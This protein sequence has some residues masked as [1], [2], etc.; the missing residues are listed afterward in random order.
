MANDG[1]YLHIE[2]FDQFDRIDFDKSKVRAGM[3]RVGKL[4]TGKAQMNVALA[5]GQGSYPRSRTGRLVHA[6]QYRVSRSGFMTKV[7]PNMPSGSSEYYPAFLHY[8]VRRGAKRGKGHKKQV[9]SGPWRIAPRANYIV[10][11][12]EDSAPKIKQ[13]LAAALQ[14]SL[15][16][17]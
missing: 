10:D 6:I 5:R 7:M 12:L 15:R 1:F 2:G 4:V 11:A 9:A 16:P 3:R 8:G 13:I 17:K 14:R